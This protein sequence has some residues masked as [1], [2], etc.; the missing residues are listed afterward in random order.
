LKEA[1]S[2]PTSRWLIAE[3]LSVCTNSIGSSIVTMCLLIVWFMW[4]II[5]ASVVDLPDPVVP[6]S[7][8]M[9]RSSSAS[10]RTTVGSESS[11]IV[12]IRWGIARQTIEMDPRCWNALI[13]KRATSAIS[14]EKSTS[15]SCANSSSLTSSLSSALSA[16]SVSSAVNGPALASRV[17]SPLTRY[18]GAEPTFRCRSEPSFSTSSRRAAFTSNMPS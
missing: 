6:V 18:S 13:L 4:S 8:T 16:P 3:R 17:S 7:S 1:V 12:L 2:M 10:S 5:A 14:N 11:S 15:C 9:P